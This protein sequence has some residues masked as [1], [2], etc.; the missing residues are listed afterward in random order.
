MTT[1]YDYIVI[2]SGSAGGVLAYNLTRAGASCLLLEAGK[3]FRKDTFPRQEADASAQLYWGGG[4]EFSQDARMAFLRGKVVGGGSVVNQALM[5]RFDQVALDDW[6]SESGVEFFTPQEMS[7]A[8]DLVE[9]MIALH[10]FQAH[11]RNRNAELFVKGCEKLG[12][13]WHYLRRA[14]SDCGFEQGND[15]IGCL[16]GCHRDSKQSTLVTWIRR[17]E[18]QGLKVQAETLVERIEPGKDMVTVYTRQGGAVEQFT[19]KNLVLSGGAFG[20][21]HLLFRSGFKPRFPALGKHFASHPQFMFFGVYDEEVNAHKGMFQSVASKDPSFRKRGFKLENVYAGPGTTAMLYGPYG[22]QH[23][24][25]M[26]NYRYMTCAEVAV[27]DEN[28]GELK[29]NNKGHLVIDKPLTDQDRRRMQDGTG[30]LKEI[31]AASGAKQVIESPF[32]FGLH[33]MGG[34]R[35]GTDAERSVVDPDFRL[36]GFQNVYVC[37]SSI[38]PN[39]PGINPGLTVM[40]LA[41]RLSNQ[42]AGEK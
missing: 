22:Q 28:M 19:C 7:Q 32:Y 14:Q 18:L 16:G 33:L 9:E 6:R 17:A 2:G 8:Y 34:C 3:H 10:T 27:R 11:E 25:F 35:I 24:A 13:E 41:Q 20:T 36:R 29:I 31:L 38:F 5:D 39:A 23:Q 4:L 15:C 26:R 37:D 21:T 30:V 42:L 12:Y 40:A 1:S